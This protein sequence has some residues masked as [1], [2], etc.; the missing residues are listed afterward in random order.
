MGGEDQYGG[1]AVHLNW[2]DERYLRTD[3]S[4]CTFVG[5]YSGGRGAAIM[6]WNSVV[7]TFITQCIIAFN[8]GDGLGFDASPMFDGVTFSVVYGNEGGNFEPGY[9]TLIEEDP[10]FC[11][12]QSGVYTLCENSPALPAG[13]M[14][15]L[16]MGCRD[17][18]CGECESAVQEKTW[19]GIKAI[20]R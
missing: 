7:N 4:G 18:G 13:N 8:T 19:G 20:F 3:I 16:L 15:S 12:M 6:G 2:V 9:S 1:G 14:W 5:N 17:M 11:A 10:L